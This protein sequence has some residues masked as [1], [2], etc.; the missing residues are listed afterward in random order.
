METAYYVAVKLAGCDSQTALLSF[1]VPV[2]Q[3]HALF[4]SQARVMDVGLILSSV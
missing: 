3:H 4:L 2:I 1:I